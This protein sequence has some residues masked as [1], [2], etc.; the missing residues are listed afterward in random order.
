MY[1]MSIKPELSSLTISIIIPLG[2]TAWSSS[3][4]NS[5]KFSTQLPLTNFSQCFLD[6]FQNSKYFSKN[7]HFSLLGTRNIFAISIVPLYLLLAILK[8]LQL[9]WSFIHSW[10]S[11]IPC[12]VFRF[13]SKF[14]IF[15]AKLAVFRVRDFEHFWIS[16]W[17]QL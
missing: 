4:Y 13:I 12:N 2:H 16:I 15:F 3:G 14:K 7:L 10:L 1:V 8:W 6:L 11:L 9:I 17:N 5:I